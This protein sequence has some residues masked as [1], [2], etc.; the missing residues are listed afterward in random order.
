MSKHITTINKL[1][2]KISMMEDDALS[3]VSQDVNTFCSEIQWVFDYLA[4]KHNHGVGILQLIENLVWLHDRT[5]KL[6]TIEQTESTS[7]ISHPARTL[8]EPLR[9]LNKR[10]ERYHGCHDAITELFC[11]LSDFESASRR[12]VK[13]VRSAVRTW[14]KLETSNGAN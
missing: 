14:K 4:S 11:A 7:Q 1:T 9:R 10:A 3:T 13:I 2:A 8:I 6:G 5:K 12:D